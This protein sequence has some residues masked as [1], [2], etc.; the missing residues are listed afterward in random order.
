MWRPIASSSIKVSPSV[1]E[2]KICIALGENYATV[3]IISADAM[4]GRYIIVMGRWDYIFAH[5]PTGDVPGIPD[6]QSAPDQRESISTHPPKQV[7][8]S[9]HSQAHNCILWRTHALALKDL[10]A[11]GRRKQK[12]SC[13]FKLH[14]VPNSYNTRCWDQHSARSLACLMSFENKNTNENLF[15]VRFSSD[16]LMWSTSRPKRIFI[17][18]PESI[19]LPCFANTFFFASSYI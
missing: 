16:P 18:L 14:I 5:R 13:F 17:F 6:G 12:P 19:S 11:Y 8:V 1:S 9:S 7:N 4:V 15:S 10:L 3:L 2:I